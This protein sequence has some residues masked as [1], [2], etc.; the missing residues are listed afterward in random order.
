MDNDKENIRQAD[1]DKQGPVTP[2]WMPWNGLLIKSSSIFREMTFSKS[3]FLASTPVLD[4]RYKYPRNQ[5]NN[6][7]YLFNSQL[8]YTLAHYFAYLEISKHNVH[9]FL[10]NSFMK[11][12]TKNLSYCNVDE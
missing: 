6:P 2:N 12:I 9:K 3:E 10:T 1:I 8:D 7:F 4:T 11:P 5:N